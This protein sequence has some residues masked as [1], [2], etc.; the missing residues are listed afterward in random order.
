M[1]MKRKALTLLLTILMSMVGANAFAHDIAVANAQ[2]KTIYYNFINNNTELEVSYR[3]TSYDSFSNEYNGTV[4]IPETVTYNEVTYRVTGI[5]GN[6]FRGC[7]GLTS[8]EIP[9]SVTSIGGF[10]FSGCS[11]LTS[12]TIGNSVTSIDNKAFQ[13]C[14]G[15]TSVEIPNSVTSIGSQA[16]Y[17]C[18]GLEK[19][20]VEDIAA[21]CNI[22]FGDYYSNPLF[23]AN[24]LYSDENTEITDLV[25]P[26]SVASIGNSV[27]YACSG[28]TSLTIGNSVTS[29]GENAFAGCSGL[30]SMLVSNGNTKYDSRGNCNAIIETASNTIILGCKNTV[31]P[32]SVT[33][34]GDRAFVGCSGLTSIEIPNSVTSIGASAFA[35]CRS[36]TSVVIPNS[37]TSIGN[38][39]FFYSGLTSVQIG[40]SV[41]SIGELAFSECSRLNKVI[42][43]DIAA[44]CNISFANDRANPL[45]YAHHLYSDENTEITDLVI[46]NSVT[47]IS[48][49]AFSY[50]SGLTSVEIPNSV[51]SIGNNTFENCSGLEKVIVRD[52]AAWCN[53]SFGNSVGQV[54]AN[55]LY[56]AHHLYS[57]ENTEITDLV[58]PNS[59]T[60]IGG[61]AFAGCSGLTSVE[62]PNSVT[63]I[64][65]GAFYLCSGLTS[66]EI[67]YSVTSIGVNAFSGC[68][69]LTSVVIPNSVTSIG[70]SAFSGCTGLTSM[71]IPNSVKSIGS[72]AFY[73]C[74]GLTSVEIGYRV[75]SIGSSAFQNCSGL[76]SVTIEKETP[77]TISSNVFSNRANATLYVPNGCVGAYMNAQNWQ[78]FKSIKAITYFEGLV[79]IG[80]LWYNL[81]GSTRSAEVTYI[82]QENTY[83][84]GEIVIPSTVIYNNKLYYVTS[85][86]EE[87]FAG[88]IDLI[89]VVIPNSVT[90]IGKEAFAGC[91]DLTSLEIPNSVTSIGID[92]FFDCWSLTSV[93]IP[94]SVTSIGGRAFGNCPGLNSIVVSSG[95]TNY[96]SRGNC[97]AIIETASNKLI[98]GCK[99]SVIPNSVTSIG[100]QAF[101]GC[102]GMTSIT[103]PNSVT[104]IG[105][106]AFWDC[107]LTSVTIPKSV[108]SIGGSAFANNTGLR[109]IKVMNKEPISISSSSFASSSF[110]DIYSQATLYVPAGSKTKYQN[111][112][113]WSNFTTIEEFYPTVTISSAGVGTYCSEY[114]L[115]FTGSAVKAYIVSAFTPSTGQVILTRVYDV[116]EQ[117]GLVVLADNAGDYQIPMGQGATIVSNML[118]GVIDDTQL[119]KVD[120]D[121]TNYVLAKKS[122][123]LGFY[124][125]KD[126]STLG[127][128]KAYLPLLTASLANLPSSAPQ[129]SLIFDDEGTTG[130][131][132]TDNGQLMMDNVYYDLSG[133]RVENPAHGLYIVNGKKVFIK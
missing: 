130:I 67:G 96:D 81:D 86:G 110:H 9:N 75:M 25:I 38:Q 34:I 76:T 64:G 111:A 126:G 46:P 53:I 129:L 68:S 10:A 55:P 107:S 93:T 2:G 82:P 31:I 20:I 61:C 6:A 121:Y 47:S 116:P 33:S 8:V 36:L 69:S 72:S 14:T 5:G 48:N 13:S 83:Y 17:G 43:E 122:G 65:D 41:T 80:N 109:S 21:W 7:S 114:A 27:F 3:G 85:I 127:A 108:T 57:D 97:N 74:T 112:Q 104:S 71:V 24:H 78:E 100:V 106:Q 60:S 84:E 4:V 124:A 32:N 132:T 119:N 29:I 58:I 113:Y 11:G 125:V 35:S 77:L 79:Q 63:S 120:G 30:T 51:T 101:Y 28:L 98:L 16:F 15:L 105:G 42:V 117:T 54:Y 73:G 1:D 92:A 12:L 131:T 91:N 39:A 90:S 128:H 115:D 87:A 44:W 26:N 94:N 45:Y 18:S 102:Q 103:I 70:S 40:N 22:S 133:R 123:N 50:C 95:N 23:Y 37:V 118:V 59:V 89:S 19:V 66:V 99:N 52:L 56:Y 49:K 88:C 62:I